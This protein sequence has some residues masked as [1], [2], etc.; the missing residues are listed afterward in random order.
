[1]LIYFSIKGHIL[2]FILVVLIESFSYS[3]SYAQ[4][5]NAKVSLAEKIYLQLDATIYTTDQTI[6]FKSIVTN[7]TD[8]TPT[9]LSGVLYVELIGPN[10]KIIEKK[11]IKIDNGIGNGFFEL[12][13]GYPNGVY[14]IRAYTEW[15]KNFETDFF[16]KQYIHVFA[17]SSKE[18]V[19][20]IR[21]VTL[22]KM[23]NNKRLI[24]AN[25]DPLAID[26]LHKNKLTLFITLD[27][28]KDT[29]TIKKNKDDKYQIDYAVPDESQFITLQFR[30]KNFL[31]R[32]K[33]IVLNEDY[34]DL[35]FFPESGELVHGMQSK[36]G[37]KALDSHG[38][39]KR[40]TGEIVNGQG[41]VVAFFK[42][43]Q[44]GMG[45]FMLNNVDSSTTY[46]ARLTSQYKERLSLIYPL[47]DVAPL[48]NVLSVN[49]IGEKIRLIA[50]SNYLKNDSIYIRVSCRGMVYYEIKGRLT[51]GVFMVFLAANKFPEG[52][53]AFTMM[54]RPMHSVAERLYFNERLE[55]RIHI[56]LSTN[57]N[58][59]SQ[60]EQTRL[61]IETTNK[62]GEE[63][64]AN[65]SLLVLNNKQMG[66]MQS[67]RQNILSY[68][69]L[70]S[71][72]KG[73]IENPGFYFSKDNDS[74]HHDLD[75][76]LLTQGWRRYHYTKSIDS[77]LFQPEPGLSVSGVVSRTLFQKK[78][79]AIELTMMTFGHSHSIQTQT[80]DSLG[81]FDF[82]VSDEYGQDLNIL[83][84]SAKKSGEKK[85]YKIAINKKES[86]DVS[87]DHIKLVESVDS[88][89]LSLVEKNIERK[90]VEDAFR[91]STGITYLDEVVIEGYK[92]T[93]ER[94][95]VMEKYGK[96]EH[97]ISGEAIEEKEEKWSYGLYSVL[98]FN[99][100]KQVI[101]KRRADG[102]LYASVVGSPGITLVVVDG[103]PVKY[104]NYGF[105]AFIPPS[106]VSSFEIIRN[107]K[108]FRELFLEAFPGV[109][110]AE[111]PYLGSAI[112]IYTHGGKGLFGVKKP[113]GIVHT[114]IPV[115]SPPREFYE[116][117][118]KNISADDWIKPDLRAL[119]H[120]A[121]NIKSDSL[122]KASMT[123]YN[124]DNI[125]E[126]Q[127]VVEAISEDGEIGYQEMFYNVKRRKTKKQ[128]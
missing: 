86:L 118:Y 1:M 63:V 26:S 43:N 12:D 34:L 99:F 101:I 109:S 115:F 40:V 38:K 77:I 75:A 112:A 6:W 7:A 31:S 110:H 107:P 10:E 102:E 81:R 21:N 88:V 104:Y 94:K 98:M 20:P 70:S 90:M 35:Q 47:P 68:F 103:V 65:L 13:Q 80:T 120:W 113:I 4:S 66:Q 25:F 41:E 64:N 91:L 54:D 23:Q 82:N 9:T 121:P 5:V 97:V 89:A 24:K 92:M 93:P 117:K 16:F 85:N 71:D 69:L 127:V 126:M 73:E 33:T 57:K 19:N 15:D 95:I 100:R 42:S 108:N 125:G 96:P 56:A 28:K 60:R 51:E 123:F 106:E 27:D 61:T 124:A 2:F 83:I 36:I 67:T 14:L 37:F 29:L 76:L 45:G 8:H 62:D 32:A 18:E 39:G 48:G 74:R 46:F 49:K 3:P 122:G 22:V 58:T 44:L 17:T 116:P 78:K 50:S 30:T 105:I 87:F 111:A 53:I 128:D 114:S 59:Y 79:K 119:V 84:Q 11:L 72:L 52:I 55:S